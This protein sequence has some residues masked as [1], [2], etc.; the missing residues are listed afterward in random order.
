MILVFP[1]PVEN[2]VILENSDN[3]GKSCCDRWLTFS[4]PY[5]CIVTKQHSGSLLLTMRL[6]W[7]GSDD[8]VKTT[9][10][11][12]FWGICEL[13]TLLTPIKQGCNPPA[14]NI[15]WLQKK[16]PKKEKNILTPVIFLVVTVKDLFQWDQSNWRN[17]SGWIFHGHRMGLYKV[18]KH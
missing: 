5:T 7:C 17:S 8:D 1:N 13:S 2:M 15:L 14:F 9:S 11:L 12:E 18:T 10:W 4:L 16:K 6:L 3:P